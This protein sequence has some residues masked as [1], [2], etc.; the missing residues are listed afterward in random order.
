MA[1][2][3]KRK[4][5]L[6]QE[7]LRHYSSKRKMLSEEKSP[8]DK[9]K[10]SIPYRSHKI[11]LPDLG[12]IEFEQLDLP[13][14]PS[15]VT[16][17]KLLELA[18]QTDCS[19]LDINQY[20]IYPS[21]EDSDESIRSWV[22]DET[23]HYRQQATRAGRNS[24]DSE[25]EELS[26]PSLVSDDD[27]DDDDVIDGSHDQN[28]VSGS[29]DQDNVNEVHD[30]NVVI[31]ESHCQN[32]DVSESHDKNAVTADQP[33]E[34]DVTTNNATISSETSHDTN[35]V[36]PSHNDG[37]VKPLSTDCMLDGGSHDLF[38]DEL[39][40]KRT[41]SLDSP[42]LPPFD[43]EMIPT[44]S[45]EP[46]PLGSHEHVEV[47]QTMPDPAAMLP[48][49]PP[50]VSHDLATTLPEPITLSFGSHDPAEDLLAALHNDESHDVVIAS[51]ESC[52]TVATPLES[53]NDAPASHDASTESHDPVTTPTES[54]DD[55]I[56][57]DTTLDNEVDTPPSSPSDVAV[58]TDLDL[59]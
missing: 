30:K 56:P 58:V 39:T 27:N 16:L 24:D 40:K 5:A 2:P 17:E 33:S 8:F 49:I 57:T 31:N 18:N 15:N 12:P 59:D 45:P 11:T 14:L 52:N 29:Q 23:P 47:T 21:D 9:N 19:Y 4:E 10:A 42:D 44:D 48:V 55:V 20:L 32:N 3:L 36:I 51:S 46:I 43:L 38:P 37:D 6:L 22:A 28:D 13:Q 7:E 25:F 54:P 53:H 26:C 1:D 35:D 34:T 50:P 41:I